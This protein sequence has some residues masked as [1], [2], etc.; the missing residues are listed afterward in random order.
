MCTGI[1]LVMRQPFT[2]NHDTSANDITQAVNS[3]Q[4]A[5]TQYGHQKHS[6]NCG[7][8]SNQHSSNLIMIQQPVPRKADT[9]P[10]TALPNTTPHEV[11]LMLTK[12]SSV[13]QAAAV[14]AVRAQQANA[15]GE[16]LHPLGHFA[17]RLPDLEAHFDPGDALAPKHQ[18]LTAEQHTTSLAM[19]S[20]WWA[21]VFVL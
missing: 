2:W 3:S 11:M 13:E 10:T 12:G 8:I 5:K 18:A 9:Q 15:S 19:C 4:L 14:I 1:E 6:S 7:Q 20:A 16:E 21:G 17:H